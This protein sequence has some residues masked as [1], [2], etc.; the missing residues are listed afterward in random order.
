MKA[1]IQ[2]AVG[3]LAAI[4]IGVAAWQTGEVL[5]INERW[6]IVRMIAGWCGSIL[7]KS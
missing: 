7:T 2:I 4:V 5:Q 3:L 1:K 6:K